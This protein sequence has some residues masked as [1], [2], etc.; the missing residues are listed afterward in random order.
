MKP[1][2]SLYKTVLLAAKRA[3]E[4]SQGAPPL[5][6]T[7][8]KQPAT[9]ALEEIREGKVSYHV[10]ESPKDVKETKKKREKSE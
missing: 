2:D 9:V 3:L 8:S 6:Q 10:T 5:I 1:G 7:T 4:L